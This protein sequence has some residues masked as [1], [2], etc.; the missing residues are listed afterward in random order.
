MK[1]FRSHKRSPAAKKAFLLSFFFLF[2]FIS[3][4][5]KSQTT[6]WIAPQDA[7]SLKNP[8]I[9]NISALKEGKALYTSYC[10]PC[11]GDRGRG[12]G[13]AASSLSTKPADHSSDNVQKETDGALFW[14]ISQGRNPM[15]TYKQTL[16]DNQ[17]WEL[18]DYIR[19]L[20]PNLAKNTKN[21]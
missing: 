11:H 1:K 21:H 6:K 5:S 2:L 19:T 9:G 4:E 17:R 20:A 16:S 15:P 14:M 8:L 13:V 18:V 3:T 10:V 7:D 12:D